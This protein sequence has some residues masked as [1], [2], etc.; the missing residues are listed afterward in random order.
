M[1]DSLKRLDDIEH[2]VACSRAEVDDL[3]SRV[4]GRVVD[5]FDVTLREVYHMD[6]I[7]DACAVM[8]GVVVSENSELC[9]GCL[10][11]SRTGRTA[12]EL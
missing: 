1:V 9:P 12:P 8:R 11:N 10:H 6:I 2:A 4:V 7:P 5:R 3:G